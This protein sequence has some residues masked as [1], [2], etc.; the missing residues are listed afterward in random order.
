MAS[1]TSRRIGIFA[2]ALIAI[3]AAAL[4]IRAWKH[5]TPVIAVAPVVKPAPAKPA[6]PATRAAAA[7]PKFSRAY[8]DVIRA[9]YP[10]FPATQPLGVPLE[11]SQAAHILL[12]DQV[13]LSGL[14]SPQMWI[15]RADA[16]PTGQVLKEAADPNADCDV[17]LVRE[18]VAYVHW[19][20]DDSGEW[21][22]YLVCRTTDGRYE[23]ISA[24]QGRRPLPKAR[25]YRWEKAVS[26]NEKVI[27][28]SARGVSIFRFSPEVSESYRE[29]APP[30]GPSSRPAAPLA[31][32]CFVLDNQGVVAWM[33]WENGKTGGRG[34]ARYIEAVGD[35][36]ATRPAFGTW[37]DLAPE[38][39]WPARILHLVPLRDGTVLLMAVDD[40][41]AV[42]LDFNTLQRTAVKEEIIAKLVE[43]LGDDDGQV[44]KKAYDE[45]SQYGS[46]IW[47]I[48]EK[49]LEAQGPEAQ[50]RMRQLLSQKVKPTLNG[51]SLLGD[52]S[53]KLVARLADGGTVFYA[54]AGVAIPNP[55]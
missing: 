53:L 7:K 55:D 14:P 45:L 2:I 27:V 49:L 36:P 46:G 3:I 11:L 51:M 6:R 20:P 42:Q 21:P 18:R 5:R 30:F 50:A 44:R 43:K 31:E 25:D 17:Q 39:G 12:H 4:G 33:P 54:P 37:T 52:K 13:Y 19:M 47:P 40:R 10:G 9:A 8:M 38:A 24:A 23:V 32:P 22:P 26:W 28:P 41:G 29:L 35:D 34:A 1:G 15:T 16:A 48:L